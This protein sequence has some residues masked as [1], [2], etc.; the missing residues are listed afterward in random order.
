MTIIVHY[1]IDSN[2]LLFYYKY[3][4]ISQRQKK[5]IHLDESQKKIKKQEVD[6]LDLLDCFPTYL[7]CLL[8]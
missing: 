2:N 1:I 8:F 6:L 3:D 4:H 5:Y 7:M